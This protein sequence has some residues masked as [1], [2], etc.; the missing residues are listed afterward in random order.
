VSADSNVAENS[1]CSFVVGRKNWI[2][3][4]TPAGSTTIAACTALIE[5][6][7]V[8]DLKPYQFAISL[9]SSRI[10]SAFLTWI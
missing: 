10:A 2:Y 9:K 5:T 3:D 8:N 4:E 7:K 1:I 6:A